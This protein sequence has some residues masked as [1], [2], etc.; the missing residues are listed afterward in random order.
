MNLPLIGINLLIFLLGFLL[1]ERSTLVK[2]IKE[3]KQNEK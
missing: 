1:G 3:D 2:E